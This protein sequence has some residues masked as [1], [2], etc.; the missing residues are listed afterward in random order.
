MYPRVYARIPKKAVNIVLKKKTNVT[1]KRSESVFSVLA[2]FVC[3]RN[4]RRRK[5]GSHGDASAL[6]PVLPF[7]CRWFL[8]ISLICA[9]LSILL[10]FSLLRFSLFLFSCA[11]VLL[12]L[13][14]V[15]SLCTAPALLCAV[16]P[17]HICA[18][19]SALLIIPISI[20][21]LAPN[22]ICFGK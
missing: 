2:R 11:S 21:M 20:A 18:L 14:A 19:R 22:S 6:L 16:Y 7:L 10:R 13:A 9:F 17:N 8:L 3:F 4:T 5:L 15:L 1:P 12:S